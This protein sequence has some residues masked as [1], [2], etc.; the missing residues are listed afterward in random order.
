M[1]VP[2]WLRK[3]EDYYQILGIDDP[4]V[5]DEDIKKSHN[6]KSFTLSPDL[7]KGKPKWVLDQNVEDLKKVN[8]AYEWLS[9]PQKRREYDKEWFERHNNSTSTNPPK[10]SAFPKPVVTPEHIRFDNVGPGNIKVASFTIQNIGGPYSKIWF[11]TPKSWMKVVRW[12][13]TS[14]SDELPLKVELEAVGT[15]WGKTYTEYITV[16]LDEEETKVKIELITKPLSS[17]ISNSKPNEG[18]WWKGFFVVALVLLIVLLLGYLWLAPGATKALGTTKS[19]PAPKATASVTQTSKVTHTVSPALAST[20]ALYQ[21]TFTNSIGMEFVLIPA[22]EFDMGSPESEKDRDGNE[23]PVHHVKISKAFYMGKYEVTQKQWREVMGNDPSNFKGDNLPVESVSWN[24]VQEFIKKLNEKEGTNRYRLPS[25]A[26][27]EYAGRAGTTT[28]YSF[29]DDESKLGEY[30]W[31]AMNS[32]S[33][34]HEVGQRK[35][36]PWGLYDMHGNVWEWVQDIYHNSYN[37]APTDGSAWEGDGSDRVLRGGCWY[38]LASYLRS[39]HRG[40]LVPDD[41]HRGG[42]ALGGRY[43]DVGFRLLRNP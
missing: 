1:P 29:G 41:L 36:N 5:S 14:V 3:W 34:T 12:Y 26:E 33:R 11:S 22:G 8:I 2:P 43:G 17:N 21:S 13:S 23:G 19:T 39:A 10:S 15:D 9:D 18:T 35:S 32:G 27:W 24:D 16:K 7:N 40:G 38:D 30:A 4:T 25:E 20:P 42:L 37:G 28:R 31:Y 6:Y